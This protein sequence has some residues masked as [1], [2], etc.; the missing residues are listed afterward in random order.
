MDQLM[1]QQKFRIKRTQAF[2]REI[3]TWSHTVLFTITLISTKGTIATLIIR[4]G[5]FLHESQLRRFNLYP[6]GNELVNS[7]ITTTIQDRLNITPLIYLCN[8]FLIAKNL[9][10]APKNY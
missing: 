1:H 7:P 2:F 10:I 5:Q 6:H 4:G 8:N 9:L 3:D